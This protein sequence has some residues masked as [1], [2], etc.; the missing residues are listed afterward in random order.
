MERQRFL[1][2]VLRNLNPTWREPVEVPALNFERRTLKC[3]AMNRAVCISILMLA[4]ASLTAATAPSRIEHVEFLGRDYVRLR[5]W[6]R[7]NN[8]E[9]RIAT[10]GKIL[11]VTNRTHRLTFEV[12]S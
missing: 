12:D 7:A 11:Q 1:P 3:A 6:A 9:I 5:D 4:L 2:K 10:G 8:F